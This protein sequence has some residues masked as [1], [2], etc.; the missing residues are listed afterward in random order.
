MPDPRGKKSLPTTLSKTEDFPEL[1]P[2][3]TAMAGRESHSVGSALFSPWSPKAV[4]A[5]WI[6]LTK[7]I[8]FSIWISEIYWLDRVQM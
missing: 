7:E 3:T 4:Q 5:L 6:L 1:W 8:R 2:P